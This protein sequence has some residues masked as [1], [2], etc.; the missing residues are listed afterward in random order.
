MLVLSR[1]RSDAYWLFIIILPLIGLGLYDL[2]QRKHTIL[3]LYPVI[4]RLRYLFEWHCQLILETANNF[5][6]TIRHPTFSIH[7]T[8][9]G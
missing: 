7:W 4:G 9:P 6:Q 1:L 3:R 2:A 5:L 8:Q